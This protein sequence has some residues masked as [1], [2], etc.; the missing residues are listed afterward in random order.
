MSDSFADLWASSVPAKSIQQQ[1]QQKLG[2][3]IQPRRPQCDAFSI[4]SASQPSSQPLVN[5]QRD[6][7]QSRQPKVTSR[8]EDAFSGLF[9]P[10]LDGTAVGRNP[11]RANMTIAERAALTQQAKAAQKSDA[12]VQIAQVPTSSTLW[13]GLDALARPTTASPRPT[14][15]AEDDFDFGFGGVSTA[16]GISS[17]IPP[18]KN[19]VIEN[20]DWGFHELSSPAPSESRSAPTKP[21]RTRAALWDL[22]E[23][24]S[25]EP[26]ASHPRSQP[27]PRSLTGTPGE[28]DFGNREDGLLGEDSDTED[29]F[30]IRGSRAEHPEDDIL[31]D[32]GKPLVRSSTSPVRF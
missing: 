23:F 10:S 5:N 28:F 27:P 22:D 19:A 21:V 2:S 6:D 31:G 24:E 11:D 1:P 32:L 13:D 18:P 9:A 4:L 26:Q 7:R 29:T 30:G 3:A 12:S 14:V 16:K 17:M 8:G 15:T 20:D 25:S